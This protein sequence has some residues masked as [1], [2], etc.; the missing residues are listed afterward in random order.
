MIQSNCMDLLL[1]SPLYCSKLRLVVVVQPLSCAQHCNSI[2]CHMPA[3]PVHH[4]LPAQTCP[5]SQWCHPTISSSVTPF[6]FYTQ[7]FQASGY[8]PMICLFPS[9]GQSIGTSASASVLLVNIQDWLPLGLTGFIS[10]LSKVLSTSQ[11]SSITTQKQKFFDAQPFLW[12][13][14]HQGLDIFISNLIKLKDLLS[15]R[16]QVVWPQNLG[17]HR[18]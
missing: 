1:L 8:F 14:A 17:T 3:F 13:N 4:Y 18:L 7:S 12:S 2:N 11:L 6:F 16:I 5:L 10:L 15:I 9:G